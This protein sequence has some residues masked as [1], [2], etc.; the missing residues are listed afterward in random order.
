MLDPVTTSYRVSAIILSLVV[1][2]ALMKR[3]GSRRR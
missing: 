1:K 3:A 2:G